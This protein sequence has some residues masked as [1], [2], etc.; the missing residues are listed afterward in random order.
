MAD[1]P[2]DLLEKYEIIE[3]IGEGGMGM[4]YK[5]RHRELQRF[6]VA[7]LIHSRIFINDDQR[8]KFI[9]EA[10]ISSGLGG[11]KNIVSVFAAGG[12]DDTPFIVFE[13][14]RGIPLDKRIKE[15]KILPLKEA[16]HFAREIADGLDFAHSRRIVHRDIKSE[17]ILVTDQFLEDEFPLAKIADFGI[18]KES[19]KP[20][21]EQ[22]AQPQAKR[23][24]LAILGTPSY[25]SPEQ[26]ASEEATELSD[27]YSVGII[28]YEMLTGA[29]PFKGSSLQVVMKHINE[30]PK[31]ICEVNPQVP[32][33][34]AE[35]VHRLL[36]KRPEDRFQSAEELVGRLDKAL[37][38]ADKWIRELN[39][40][41]AKSGAN[42]RA[43]RTGSLTIRGARP[44]ATTSISSRP[45]MKLAPAEPAPPPP[46]PDLQTQAWDLYSQ[47]KLQVLIAGSTLTLLVLFAVYR[48]VFGGGGN[49]SL[50]WVPREL[51]VSQG[52][53]KAVVEWRSEA[54]YPSSV[55]YGLSGVPGK[56]EAGAQVDETQHSVKLSEI[57][58]GKSYNY[59]IVYPSGEKSLPHSFIAARPEFNFWTSPAADKGIHVEGDTNIPARV[60]LHYSK[61]GATQQA[62]AREGDGFERLHTFYLPD[63]DTKMDRVT[64]LALT[65]KTGET[66]DLPGD[67]IKQR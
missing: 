34:V 32:G 3:K 39:D 36:E 21:A 40:P 47:Y 37:R 61:A 62:S 19:P 4:V 12:E 66:F 20:G 27:L 67:K 49:A 13:Y 25:M 17:N 15:A 59:R 52:M 56:L 31:D 38:L 64:K 11:H 50:K 42:P 33:Q 7:K 57:A 35:I 2:K 5:V 53:E 16:L 1:F 54:G 41:A 43:Q 63:F 44:G 60:V 24:D 9:K 26:A 18:A 48:V 14:V 51:R 29:V 65:F 22:A 10:R 28:M 6:D 8:R 23:H 55:E 46:P 58:A 45:G 30:V